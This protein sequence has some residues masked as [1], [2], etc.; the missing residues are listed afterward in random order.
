MQFEMY[1]FFLHCF[2]NHP[3]VTLE[4]SSEGTGILTC[5]TKLVMPDVAIGRQKNLT[6]MLS[7]CTYLLSKLEESVIPQNS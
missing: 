7:A 3:N 5:R 2:P 1:V 6:L 4:Q